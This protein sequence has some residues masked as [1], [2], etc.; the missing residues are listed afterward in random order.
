MR[1]DVNPRHV[2]IF[3]FILFFD[4]SWINFRPLSRSP[5]QSV[6]AFKK[7][8]QKIVAIETKKVIPV[9]YPVPMLMKPTKRPRPQTIVVTV[10][11]PMYKKKKSCGC[12]KHHYMPNLGVK[13]PFAQQPAPFPNIPLPTSV[14]NSVTDEV[15]SIS[16][17][18][19]LFNTLHLHKKLQ[20]TTTSTITE[21]AGGQQDYGLNYNNYNYDNYNYND[22]YRNEP[23]NNNNYNYDYG[24]LNDYNGDYSSLD[25]QMQRSENKKK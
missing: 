21:M 4:Q 13:C 7:C 9:P 16:C 3:A 12:Q 8:K 24:S 17:L 14:T 20:G 25:E 15:S 23:L 2:V 6:S 22:D 19:T 10:P 11:Q 5:S 18:G 1:S